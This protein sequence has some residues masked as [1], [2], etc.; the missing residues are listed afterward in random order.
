MWAALVCLLALWSAVIPA[1]Y[2][3]QHGEIVELQLDP[4]PE[5]L[6]LSATLQLELP[7]LVKDALYKGISVFFITEAEVVRQR[8]YWSDKVVAQASRFLRLSYQPLT[9]RW[10]VV[11][12]S[13]PFAPSGLGVSLGQNFDTLQ[14][15]LASMQRI[16]RWKI[17]DEGQVDEGVTYVMNFQFR[18]DTSQLPRPLQIGAVGRSGWNMVLARSVPLSV[19]EA[20]R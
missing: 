15:A 7:E 1:A 5:G 2:A 16:A 20:A 8:W 17:A 19:V 6:Y 18:L 3:Q 12:S 11:Q 10:R 13:T 9:R 14:D 4:L